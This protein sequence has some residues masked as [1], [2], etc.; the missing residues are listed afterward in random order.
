MVELL[1]AIPSVISAAK[2]SPLA[3]VALLLLLVA[4]VVVALKVRRNK[5]LLQSLTKLPEKDRLEALQAEMGHLKIKGG[6]SAEQWLRH[7]A[8]QY[9]FA[10]FALSCLLIVILVAILWFKREPTLKPGVSLNLHE[11]T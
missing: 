10:A 11:E 5:Q 9:C 4:W 3:L 6:I 1:K 2:E 8:Q 7:Q